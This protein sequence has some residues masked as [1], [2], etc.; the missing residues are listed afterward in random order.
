MNQRA[1]TTE[2]LTVLPLRTDGGQTI[3]GPIERIPAESHIEVLGDST[4][5][6]MVDV[7]WHGKRYAA[8]AVDVQQRCTTDGDPSPSS[9]GS[10]SLNS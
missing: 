3:Y 6:A 1:L 5:G 2:S 8:F 9:R 7:E 4:L 10:H